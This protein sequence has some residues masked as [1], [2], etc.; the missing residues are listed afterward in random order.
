METSLNQHWAIDLPFS[1]RAITNR[2]TKIL[3]DSLA[4]EVKKIKNN[5]R[6][7]TSDIDIA[8]I[9][10]QLNY[11]N[12]QDEVLM[13]PNFNLPSFEKRLNILNTR[14]YFSRT[15]KWIGHVTSKGDTYF[16]AKLKDLSF[17]GTDEIAEFEIEEISF[18]DREMI[19]IGAAF[20]WS[21]GYSNV[22]GQ[23]KKESIIRF[24]RFLPWSSVDFDQATDRANDLF[25]QLN[26]G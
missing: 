4:G 16:N 21:L 8:T 9:E 22:N 7:T 19:K 3:L 6:Q 17:G 15:Q 1:G 25:N 13:N 26:W 14:N 5:S 10:Q 24:Q 11:G 12:S 18:E 20:Y 2:E 23:R